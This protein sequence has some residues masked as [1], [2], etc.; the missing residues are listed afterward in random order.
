MFKQRLKT[1]SLVL[2]AILAACVVAGLAMILAQLSDQW[3][4]SDQFKSIVGWTGLVIV[5]GCVL[6]L[7]FMLLKGLYFFIQWLFVEPYRAWKKGKQI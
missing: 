3:H 2:L 6:V 4:P 1:T 5:G 7:L